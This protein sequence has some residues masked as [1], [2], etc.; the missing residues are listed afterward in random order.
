MFYKKTQRY[1]KRIWELS[2]QRLFSLCLG[3]LL[4]VSACRTTPITCD[5]PLGCIIVHP[6]S[7]VRLAA[8][9]PMTGETAVWGQ[10]LSRGINLALS[11]RENDLLGHSVELI[12]LDSA[13]DPTSSQQIMQTID[14][15]ETLLA[16]I[17]PACSEVAGA[18]LPTMR[19][20]NWLLI[21][22]ASTAPSLTEKQ[23]EP[24]FFRSVPN[25]ITQATAA[26]NFAYNVLGARQ[27]AVFQDETSY[28]S[29]LAQQFAD[30]FAQLGGTVVYTGSITSSQSETAD[31]L[32]NAAA[33]P[34][35]LIYLPLFEPEASLLIN[36]LAETAPLNR[37][38]LLGADSLFSGH[39][40]SSA[41]AAAMGMLLTNPVLNTPA[42]RGFLD[43]W[44]TLYD[45]PPTSPAPAY[46]YDATQLLLTAVEDVAVVGQT[47][48]LVIG[49]DAL[50][51]QLSADDGL[52][53]LT[54]KLHCGNTGECAALNYGVYE[55]TADVLENQRWPPP[56]IWQFEPSAE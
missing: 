25:H 11:N 23:S 5:D 16:V 22:P 53:G 31:L 8:L 37:A 1:K 20:N 2:K 51:Q 15:D 27:T 32:I 40:A 18:V 48:A 35:D 12:P 26:A 41:G 33:I 21:S 14:G 49:R 28:N 17:G 54:G 42:Y 29:L 6:N 55:L 19:R 47:G 39:F 43:D 3:L 24:A 52:I 7:P 30:I 38:Q 36:Q 50:R 13:C 44:V 4:L 46:A 10:E 56:L 34:S 45:T 9:L